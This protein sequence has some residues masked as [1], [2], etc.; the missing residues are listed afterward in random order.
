[1]CGDELRATD[2]DM[3]GDHVVP[4]LERLIAGSYRL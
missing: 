2:G 3:D 1:M 4:V